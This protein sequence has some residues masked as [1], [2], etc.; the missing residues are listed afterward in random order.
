[1][2]GGHSMAAAFEPEDGVVYIGSGVSLSGEIYAQETVVVDGTVEGEI[3]CRRLV[4]ESGGVLHGKFDVAEAEIRG[5][6]T[7]DLKVKHLLEVEASARI[8]GRWRCG[9]IVVAR[10][11]VLNGTAGDGQV[12]TQE[13]PSLVY[14]PGLEPAAAEEPTPG[15]IMQPIQRSELARPNVFRR[16]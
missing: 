16:R 8:N 2:D 7:G 14:F 3:V 5:Q 6:V 12:E 10:G 4:V 13:A 15:A 1:M 11:A 9:E